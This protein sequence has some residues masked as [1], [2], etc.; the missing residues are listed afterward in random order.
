MDIGSLRKAVVGLGDSVLVVGDENMARIH[1]HTDAPGEVLNRGTAIG[2]LT[3]VK[4]DN[5]N[6]QAEGFVERHSGGSTLP[7]AAP[8][9]L[10]GEEATLSCIA[11]ASGKGLSDVF[12]DMGCERVVSGG[13]TM[14]PSTREILDAVEACSAPEVIVLPNDKNI[15]MAAEQAVPLAGKKVWVV[16]SRSIPQGLAAVLAMNAERSAEDNVADM[17]EAISSVRTVEIT[18]AVRSTSVGGVK[19]EEGQIIAI[20]DDVLKLSAESAEEAAVEAL[21]GL[22]TESTSLIS[23]YHGAETTET[24]AEAL[25]ERLRAEYPGHEADVVYGGQ[26]HYLY[27]VSIE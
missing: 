26:P 18:R 20:V 23:L 11:V 25:A 16:K 5:I 13:P 7:S 12:R 17:E 9:G 27:I 3:Q 1:V 8:T 6:R 22:A 2:A 21:R 4:V 19:V 14:N 15:I 24:Q 10:N